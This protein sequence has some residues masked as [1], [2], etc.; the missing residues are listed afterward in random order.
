MPKY[1]QTLTA[2]SYLHSDISTRL[3][4]AFDNLGWGTG[5]VDI[6]GGYRF[7]ATDQTNT[8]TTPLVVNGADFVEN[9]QGKNIIRGKGRKSTGVISMYLPGVKAF[10]INYTLVGDAGATL[11]WSSA[12]EGSTLSNS[13]MRAYYLSLNTSDL[14]NSDINSHWRSAD[15]VLTANN[16]VGTS[17]SSQWIT[18]DIVGYPTVL[19]AV[20]NPRVSVIIDS[21]EWKVDQNKFAFQSPNLD[22]PTFEL[23]SRTVSGA[24]YTTLIPYPIRN[25]KVPMV[26]VGY[27]EI[28]SN[29]YFRNQVAVKAHHSVLYNTHP[30]PS[31]V[32]TN[33][34]HSMCE[35][36]GNSNYSFDTI[37]RAGSNNTFDGFYVTM[38]QNGS[39]NGSVWDTVD[40][41]SAFTSPVP[42][43]PAVRKTLVSV[44][45]SA[46]DGYGG[47]Y[48]QDNWQYGTFLTHHIFEVKNTTNISEIQIPNIFSVGYQNGNFDKTYTVS[49]SKLKA[50]VNGTFEV[51]SIITPA[52][53]ITTKLSGAP[54]RVTSFSINSQV[55]P[56]YY[57]VSVGSNTIRLEDSW[58]GSYPGVDFSTDFEP[59]YARDIRYVLST[60]NATSSSIISTNAIRYIREYSTTSNNIHWVEV[61]AFTSD[62]INRALNKP[63]TGAGS[64]YNNSVIVN[65][66]TNTSVYSEGSSMSI[67]LGELFE[68][69]SLKIWH[70]YADSR[71][72]STRLEVSPDGNTWFDITPAPYNETSAGKTTNISYPIS[73][74][75]KV[76]TPSDITTNVT[77][78]DTITNYVSVGSV[79]GLTN[80]TVRL[81]QSASGTPVSVRTTFAENWYTLGVWG[82]HWG[83]LPRLNKLDRHAVYRINLGFYKRIATSKF[84][85]G[86]DVQMLGVENEYVLSPQPGSVF[87]P[88]SGNLGDWNNTQAV[89]FGKRVSVFGD[90][91][92]Y[93][94]AW[95]SS[96]HGTSLQ[97]NNLF[98]LN[99]RVNNLHTS[100]VT[101]DGREYVAIF[102][103]I[104]GD[105]VTSSDQTI[106]FRLR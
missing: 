94:R 65:G 51:E 49:I 85:F 19:M 39:V 33:K 16:T 6:S 106:S 44:P 41:S 59:N 67:D 96:P 66:D 42:Q 64:Y 89:E 15:M 58:A 24:H 69:T 82:S 60:S 92:P 43:Y 103:G 35:V 100:Y 11:T 25:S 76:A 46:S 23:F 88:D 101:D 78:G 5:K 79:D 47:H 56:G 81:V 18:G 30:D 37:I 34:V 52:R 4:E 38:E 97:A 75:V 29:N 8:D 84:V 63:V 53:T 95:L 70:Y 21:V 40:K 80:N 48:I 72:Y 26:R 105:Y 22:S 28:K 73:T 1:A 17:Y 71:S 86:L 12:T 99:G 3:K 45:R 31:I 50:P 13:Y 14:N 57:A 20:N 55:S 98:I 61:Q 104:S 87:N 91:R 9:L 32:G 10:R 93:R 36:V 83:T 102:S 27:S 7:T 2:N 90:G 68:I 74:T 54:D 77:I 62:N